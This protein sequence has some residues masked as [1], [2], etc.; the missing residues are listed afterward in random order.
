[1]GLN[2]KQVKAVFFANEKGIITNKE[3]KEINKTSDRTAL[4]D[5]DNFIELNLFVKEGKKKGTTFINLSMAD[6]W[7]I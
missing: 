1:M 6:V 4:R 2:D 7:R 5:L 3:Y